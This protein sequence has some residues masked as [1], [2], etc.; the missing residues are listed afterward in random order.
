MYIFFFSKYI[1][2]LLLLTL[3][4]QREIK[5]PPD[6]TGYLV[7]GVG[8]DFDGFFVL[9]SQSH[10]LDHKYL[11]SCLEN[12]QQRLCN[13]WLQWTCN[14]KITCP[15]QRNMCNWGLNL[16]NWWKKPSTYWQSYG[17]SIEKPGYLEQW[18]FGK[19]RNCHGRVKG[20]TI[21]CFSTT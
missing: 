3:T 12:Q 7:Y 1:H 9:N 13:W 6:F 4:Q 18:R 15:I 17:I 5:P 14:P 21:S 8:W 10:E 11:A 16:W 20:L 2:V 19:H